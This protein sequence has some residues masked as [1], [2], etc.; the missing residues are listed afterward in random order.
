MGVG[1]FKLFKNKVEEVSEADLE[2][3]QRFL[4]TLGA[5]QSEG[6]SLEFDDERM[7]DADLKRLTSYLGRAGVKCEKVWERF[8]WGEWVVLK[9][10]GETLEGIVE[11]INKILP[12]PTDEGVEPRPVYY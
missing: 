6:K 12:N 8:Q 9:F 10:P 3:I 4:E 5:Y 7:S 11:K 1:V 2:M